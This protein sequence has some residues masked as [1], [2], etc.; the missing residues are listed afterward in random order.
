LACRYL[1]V[2]ETTIQVL[3]E[4]KKG[5]TDRGYYW[6]Y[7][8]SEQKLV[9]FDYQPSRDA[10]GPDNILKDFKGHLQTDGYSVYDH[11]DKCPGIIL[12]GCM[13]HARRKFYDAKENDRERC[14]Y[15]LIMFGQLYAL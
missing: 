8:N 13:A 6:L 12:M 2:D 4:D 11:F 15:A 7:F 10:D 1:H 5:K 3:D 9:L 14:E